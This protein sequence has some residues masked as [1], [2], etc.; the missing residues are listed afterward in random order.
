MSVPTQIIDS[1]IL[2]LAFHAYFLEKQNKVCSNVISSIMLFLLD[3][4]SGWHWGRISTSLFSVLPLF[5]TSNLTISQSTCWV[6][7]GVEEDLGDIIVVMS[8]WKTVSLTKSCFFQSLLSA[9]QGNKRV[10]LL[11]TLWYSDSISCRSREKWGSRDRALC[12]TGS[13]GPRFL[14]L[15]RMRERERSI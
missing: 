14:G 8:A 7:A 1:M 13:L 9:W 10:Y 3:H 5:L 12:L 11:N 4:I 6:I 2:W 15:Q